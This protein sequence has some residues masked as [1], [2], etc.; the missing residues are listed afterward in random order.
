[1]RLA[2]LLP[3]R[4]RVACATYEEVRGGG[5][6]LVNRPPGR[7]FGIFPVPACEIAPPVLAP[8]ARAFTCVHQLLSRACRVEFDWVLLQL[9]PFF[10]RKDIRAD[11]MEMAKCLTEGATVAQIRAAD[12]ADSDNRTM[13]LSSLLRQ[14]LRRRPNA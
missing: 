12:S 3:L 1:M 8:L 13:R 11:V 2:F 6:F 7:H 5:V 4:K 10:R 9:P 14:G